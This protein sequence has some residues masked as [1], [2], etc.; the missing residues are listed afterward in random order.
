M[1]RAGF[2]RGLGMRSIQTGNTIT[3]DPA[4]RY[5]VLT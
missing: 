1:L 2:L 5:F 3:P 4:I